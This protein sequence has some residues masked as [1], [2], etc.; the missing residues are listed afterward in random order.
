MKTRAFHQQQ[1][2]IMEIG[3]LIQWLNKDSKKILMWPCKKYQAYD[4]NFWCAN[5]DYLYQKHTQDSWH[6]INFT[7]FTAQTNIQT[8]RQINFKMLNGNNFI[9]GTTGKT[10]P[11]KQKT[12]VWKSEY[13]Y[14][15]YGWTSIKYVYISSNCITVPS[16]K[17]VKKYVKCHLM[18]VKFVLESWI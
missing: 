18:L 16:L 7:R 12:K 3:V 15:S 2:K 1:Q 11:L 14:K 10:K 13:M 5:V 6:W 8:D 17:S 9:N 4:H